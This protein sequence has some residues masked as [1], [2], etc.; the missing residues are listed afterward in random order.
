MCV[1]G[2][3]GLGGV[4]MVVRGVSAHQKQLTAHDLMDTTRNLCPMLE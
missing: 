4:G 3:V 2:W 1:R